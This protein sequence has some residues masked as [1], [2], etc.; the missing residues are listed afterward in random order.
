MDRLA[1]REPEPLI[2]G[3]PRRW[4]SSTPRRP[5]WRD[6]GRQGTAGTVLGQP[7]VDKLRC[8][9]LITETDEKSKTLSELPAARGH[10]AYL[11]HGGR[12]GR[13][14]DTEARQRDQP[15]YTQYLAARRALSTSTRE[16]LPRVS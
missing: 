15:G 14:T 6:E 1:E 16:A 10:L 3:V 12:R 2:A 7:D 8:F 11:A 5:D 13:R 4:S 9:E